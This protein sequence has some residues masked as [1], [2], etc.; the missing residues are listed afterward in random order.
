[1]PHEE[2]RESR[3]KNRTFPARQGRNRC[4]VLTFFLIVVTPGN[5][6]CEIVCHRYFYR[7]K[8]T[9]NNQYEKQQQKSSLSSLTELLMSDSESFQG[10]AWHST[11]H[12]TQ[13]ATMQKTI[14][15]MISQRRPN[16]SAE[17]LSQTTE[18]SQRVEKRLYWQANSLNEYVCNC[19]S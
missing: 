15:D 13:R 2:K 17:W 8:M 11:G 6:D 14:Y 19:I 4:L 7:Q 3:Q 18:V 12:K 16:A 5:L 1:M 10:K 9:N